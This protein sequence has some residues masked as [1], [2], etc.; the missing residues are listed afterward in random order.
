[1]KHKIISSQTNCSTLEDQYRT[2]EYRIKQLESSKH[3]HSKIYG[4]NIPQVLQYF[5]DNDF[6][7]LGF[8]ES[9]IGPIG[10]VSEM[11]LFI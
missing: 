3:D 5:K 9:P 2:T 6:Q 7:K 1:M 4:Q 8:K 10:N 11:L